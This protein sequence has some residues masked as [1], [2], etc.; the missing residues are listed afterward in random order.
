[1]D[2]HSRSRP[3]KG[4]SALRDSASSRRWGRQPPGDVDGLVRFSVQSAG[5]TAGI[6]L[7]EQPNG[8]MWLARYDG[9]GEI[10]VMFRVSGAW[11]SLVKVGFGVST[12]QFYWLRFDLQASNVA[13]KAWPDGTQEPSSPTWSGS[14][15]AVGTAGQMGLYG[16]ATLHAPVDFDSFS[17]NAIIPLPPNSAISGNVTDSVTGNAIAGVVVSTL[18]ASATTTTDAQGNY[19]LGVQANTYTVVFTGASAGYNENIV[20]GVQA[21]LGGTATA[22]QPLVAIPPFTAMDLFTQPDQISRLGDLYRWERLE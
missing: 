13:V 8:N 12:T 20:T 5:D 7:R 6:I 14:R 18:P 2:W 16:Y 10:Q 22:N 4:S 15:S 11:T 1:M 19:S 21:P 3:T 9:A 17:V